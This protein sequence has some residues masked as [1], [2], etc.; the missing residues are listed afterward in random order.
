MRKNEKKMSL[1]KI[2]I[3]NFPY[4]SNRNSVP[5]MTSSNLNQLKDYNINNSYTKYQS[6]EEDIFTNSNSNSRKKNIRPLSHIKLN[7]N[8]VAKI[9][10]KILKSP[11][12]RLNSGNK[13][14]SLMTNNK[15]NN[16]YIQNND[17]ESH[18][19]DY[20]DKF[21]LF[22]S[23][24]ALRNPSGKANQQI[25]K[26]R[27]EI[28]K[29]KKTI[30][31][32]EEDLNSTLNENSKLNT[33][34]YLA[35][36]ELKKER[37]MNLDLKEELKRYKRVSNINNINN[38]TNLENN[39]SS[40]IEEEEQLFPKGEQY[41]QLIKDFNI[42]NEK[43]Q[44]N[45]RV[46]P[47]QIFF[48]LND[49]YEP[50]NKYSFGIS[51]INSSKIDNTTF[52]G[53]L[54]NKSGNI[55]EFGTSFKIDYFFER[56]QT[57]IAA[58]IINE[59]EG[60]ENIK[61]QVSELMKS[62][63]NKLLK[64]IEN[65]GNLQISY[66]SVKNQNNLL[67]N[68]ISTFEFYISLDNKDLFGGKKKLRNSYFV[69][70]NFKDGE[71]KRAVYKS[72]EYN[73]EINKINKTSLITFTSDILC[74]EKSDAIFFE[75]YCP[76]MDKTNYIG[77]SSFNLSQLESKLKE[78]KLLLTKIRSN[79]G[80]IG[81]LEINYNIKEKMAFQKFIKKGQ[82]NLDIAI[83]YT[84]SNGDP[85]NPDS[86]HYIYGKENDYEKAIKSCGEIIAY[87]DADQLFPVYGFGG[88]P[89]NKEIVNHC[90]NINFNEDNP[91]ILGIDKIIDYYK[92][93]LKKV[94][95]AYPTYF[96]QIIKKV[97]EE[98]NY[99]LINKKEENHYY[100]LMILTDGIINDTQETI[101]SIV[102]A[103]KLP[104]SIV[105]IGIGDSNFTS[106][107]ILDG[108]EKPLTTSSG[109]IR[110]RDI[111][112]FVEFNKFK[113]KDNIN[114]GVELA[115][116]VLKEIPRQVE[117]YYQFCGEFYESNN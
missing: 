91:N 57:I 40:I 111:V 10:D 78:D 34:L 61:Y 28:K 87:Y 72:N 67:S 27:E 88:I 100:V 56:E 24:K 4:I 63:E 7:E 44:K 108:D 37:E 21:F 65:I 54:E 8:K 85:S 64:K 115:Q 47:I 83:D 23:Q 6:T 94:R 68:E 52:L 62:P 13:R 113:D 25:D 2:N 38:D 3:N 53:Y 79:K 73:F 51:I 103:S 69:I 9:E 46:E 45:S 101:D 97:I 75:L 92:E 32:L 31:E 110:K 16:L 35:R 29:L 1:K 19:Y 96:S 89:P 42:N 49:V 84:K 117:E 109:E 98:I 15:N 36:T 106:M 59:E 102:E 74:D 86:L 33:D 104:L 22:K 105:I 95:L 17:N 70:R 43:R 80:P 107:E 18:N 26:Y 60:E 48:T 114:C 82:I 30:K 76:S 20:A 58:P 41:Y 116:E 50:Y 39:L 90:F 71:S 11:S 55:I 77:F 99:D 14:Y 66:S 81:Q 5:L 93:S 12:I 112:Q